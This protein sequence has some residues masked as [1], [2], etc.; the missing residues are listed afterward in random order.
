MVWLKACPKCQ[1]ALF[2]EEDRFGQFKSC[3]QCGYTLD[4]AT[5]SKAGQQR[6]QDEDAEKGSKVGGPG[7]RSFHNNGSY[8]QC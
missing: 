7:T 3:V 2:L 1:G 6:G 5:N 8:G 4:L